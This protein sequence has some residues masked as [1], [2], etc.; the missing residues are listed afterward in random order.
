MIEKLKGKPALTDCPCGGGTYIKCCQRF[1]SGAEIPKNALE[2]MRSRYTA[3]VLQ[4]ETYLRNSWF[5]DTLPE[6][7]I[8]GE[9]DVKWI[10]LQIIKHAHVA[11][12]DQATVEF[13]ARFKVGGRAHRLHEISNFV[14]QADSTGVMRWFYVDGSFPNQ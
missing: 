13:V 5:P 12:T 9:D 3:F 4:D 10:G 8:T 14:R 2:L 6:E 7:A 11:A 1:I